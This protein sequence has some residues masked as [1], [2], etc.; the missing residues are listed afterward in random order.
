MKVEIKRWSISESDHLWLED[1]NPN[2]YIY[3]D[4]CYNCGSNMQEIAK[5]LDQNFVT[6]LSTGYCNVCGFVQRTNNLSDKWYNEH[7]ANNWLKGSNSTISDQQVLS[8]DRYVYNK[9]LPYMPDKQK[10]SVLD[11]GCGI[12]QRL[13]P[14]YQA[15]YNVYGFDPSIA[16]T[17]KASE[18][19]RNLKIATAEEYFLNN[20]EEYDVIYFF[21]VLQFIENPF[22]VIEIASNRLTDGGLLF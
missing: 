10:I 17:K 20:P 13:L 14:F 9:L 5:V 12:G 16:R 6:G 18:R 2:D 11:A 19:M 8:E 7:F 21:N 15:G 3:N 1:T 22:K 4:T